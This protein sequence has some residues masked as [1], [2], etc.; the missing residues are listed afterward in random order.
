M[1][2]WACL[3]P[4]SRPFSHTFLFWVHPTTKVA[5]VDVEVWHWSL[6][7][8]VVKGED[9]LNSLYIA[10]SLAWIKRFPTSIT[11]SQR[12][13]RIMINHGTI[14]MSATFLP[15]ADVG[16]FPT[17][18]WAVVKVNSLWPQ[19]FAHMGAMEISSFLVWCAGDL[20]SLQPQGGPQNN[21]FMCL[22]VYWQVRSSLDILT[23]KPL[24]PLI[25]L[26]AFHTILEIF[27]KYLFTLCLL[28]GSG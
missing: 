11:I 12:S 4:W 19:G 18:G 10:V 23:L 1:C 28:S 16:L 14:N 17:I 20:W 3:V 21:S 13:L 27:I 7:S 9:Y 2:R 26:S 25:H 15:C 24:Y 8:D 22:F 5:Y 6:R